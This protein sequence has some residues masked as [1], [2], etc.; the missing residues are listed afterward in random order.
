[1]KKIHIVSLVLF[2]LAVVPLHISFAQLIGTKTIPGSYSSI[3]SALTDLNSQGVG[4]GGV[5]FNIAANYTETLTSM[6]ILTA[7]GTSANP[8]VFQKSG[9]GANPLITSY[10]GTATP[11]S[12]APDGIWA[13]QGSDYVTINGI[14][15]NDPNTSNPGTM[16]FGYGLFKNSVVDGCQNNLITNC[17][18]TL[19]KVNNAA[20]VSPMV[21]GSVGILVINSTPTSSTTALVPTISL[22]SNSYNK[23]YANTIQNAN[24]GIVLSGY[25]DVLPFTLGDTGNDI[26]GSLQSTGNNIL[27]FGGGASDNPSAGIRAIQQW[28]L[29]ISNNTINNNN[30][31]GSN[32]ATTLR[33]IYAQSG[34]S[35][36]VTINNNTLTLNSS[37]TTSQVSVIENGIGSTPA[38]NTIS[39]NN[40][41][42]TNCSN[43]MNTTGLWYGIFNNGAASS[44][45]NISNNSF[46]G[47]STKSVSGNVY[48]IY[49]NAS[50]TSS[51][52][53][54]NNNLSFAF[55]N[56]AAYTGTLYGVYN[57]GATI[58]TNL[59]MNSN[60]FS[61]FNFGSYAN[62]G[63]IQF[64]YNSKPCLNNSYNGNTWT[65]LNL[66]HTGTEYLINNSSNSQVSLTVSNN[67]IV[68][69]YTRNNT[70]GNMYCYYS[71]ASSLGTSSQIISGNNFSNINANINGTGSFYGIYTL[72]GS[73]SPYP[74]KSVYN[75]ILSN[76]NYK[77]SNTFYGIY[78]TN[79]G[80]GSTTSGSSVYNNT[81]ANILD[82]G[83]TYA[84]GMLNTNASPNYPIN[85][86]NNTVCNV[87]SNGKSALVYGFYLGAGSQGQ[88]FY[89]NKVYNIVSNGTTGA[90][91]GV[92]TLNSAPFN[93]F[94]NFVG[95]IKAPIA[96]PTS[97]PYLAAAGI[98]LSSGSNINIQHNT[99]FLNTTS[100]GTNF[101][102][103][104]IYTTSTV[105]SLNLQNNIFVNLSTSK[106]AGYSTAFMRNN[107]NFTNYSAASNNNLFFTG[108]SGTNNPLYYDCSVTYSTLQSF[109]S[110]V[111][112][113]DASSITE[114][115]DFLSVNG[116]DSLYLHINPAKISQ[117]ESGGT[118]ISSPSIIDDY[119]GNARYPNNGYPNNPMYP[120]YAPDM[121]ADEF[122][123]IPL[124]ISALL[125]PQN[126]STGIPAN[127]NLVWSKSQSLLGYHIILATDSN[128]TNIVYNDSTLTDSIYTASNLMPLTYYYWKVRGKSTSAVWTRFS[129]VFNFKTSGTAARVTLNSPLNGMIDLPSTISFKWFKSYDITKNKNIQ[130]NM[131]YWFEYSADSMFTTSVIDTTLTDTTKTISG[132]NTNTKYYWRVKAKNQIGWGEFSLIWSVTTVP[133]IPNIVALVSPLNNITGLP[134]TVTFNW[135]KG[136]ETL[137]NK[138][139]KISGLKVSPLTISRY[140]FEYSTDST[141]TT[142]IIDSTLTDTTKTLTDLNNIT[143][144]FWR[145]KSKN[146]TGW[147]GYSSV[148]SFTTIVPIPGIPILLY[149]ANNS[150]GNALSLNLIW[151]KQRYA[152]G[153][154]FMISTDPD[155]STI[156]INDS[157]LTDS[158]KSVSG[159]TSLTNYY[160]KVRAKSIS[161]WSPFSSAFSF[162]TIGAASQVVL[163]S[164]SNNSTG[165]PVN[166]AFRWYRAFDLTDN[167][168]TV[169]NYWFELSS[170]S[171]FNTIT[172]RDTTLTDTTKS[173]TGLSNQTKYWWRV[174]AK[175][176]I[177]W[178]SFSSVWNLTTIIAAPVAPVLLAPVNNAAGVS[179]MPL[180]TW[181]MVSGAASFRLQVS[182]DSNFATT[183]Y[184]TSGVAALTLT[185]PAGKLTGLT[186]YYWRVNAAN[187]GGTSAW[188]TV[189][190]FMT[191]QNL[192]LNLKVYLEGF[193]DGTSQVQDTVTVYLAGAAMPHAFVDS[194]KVFLS[195]TGTSAV[196]FN[197]APNASYYIVIQHRNHLQT[198]SA[199][200]QAFVTNTAVNYD[201][202]TAAS[203]AFGNNMKQAGSVWVLYGGDANTDGSVDGL[204]IVAFVP[205]FGT[206]G[207]LSCDFNG[208]GD[209]NASDVFIISANY[210]LT[211]AVP[212]VNTNFNP[213]AKQ[214]I[215]INDAIK[216]VNTN[217]NTNT[218]KENVK[219][220]PT[221]NKKT[222]GS[223]NVK[224]QN[225]K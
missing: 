116:Q 128:F 137:I 63:T 23:F 93:I 210:G 190:N 33:G 185:I 208:D 180:I 31:S 40:N 144:Y 166:L 216:N 5:T 98:Y 130:T 114:L 168:M 188:S 51:I 105:S 69:G 124:T 155:F 85:T 119:D 156:I 195:T 4:S 139:N 182:T 6:L 165:L 153:Y 64:I 2:F 122:G 37:V 88:N 61:N 131:L 205:Q 36:N 125:S 220:N 113:R 97:A 62:S 187:A 103:S 20:G 72:D 189:W 197:K 143:R 171:L 127:V 3:S 106:G 59:N 48:L 17:V 217:T 101:S 55:T 83:L 79:L 99:V 164:P 104:S 173:I 186:K 138:S 26:G 60:N 223:D 154:N 170:D 118:I 146:Q 73:A 41:V 211:I 42:I 108:V 84:Y 222:T 39:I 115:P 109:K 215:D 214:K 203:Q 78:L 92:Y 56:S 159:L 53:M 169:S 25:A 70:A 12:A 80:D 112:P 176:Q 191:I 207:Y 52:N 107:N 162:K 132:L 123:G 22:G 213:P 81:V 224:K 184:D 58:T 82:S 151:N 120:A 18:I 57:G 152:T 71:F 7:T 29:N 50:V 121:G 134:L 94:N 43:D 68:N 28:G 149:P 177:G 219:Q 13:L 1:M 218:N 19:N 178:G 91:Y 100:S 111:A 35:A 86:Y 179:L 206:Q 76:I 67:S 14:D 117:I 183:Q 15:L 110:L 141:F 194:A 157:T 175:N 10:V 150:A 95:D 87:A 209:V 199:L 45:L 32:H 74:K 158:V 126:N 27:N 192:S 145:V 204:D 21:D 44:Y 8:I 174:K 148:W 201:F 30:G 129:N 16:E 193:W 225:K 200:T 202:T 181:N 161:G 172:L 47:N 198:W 96:S 212:T 102:S 38:E 147:S 24:Y 46:T 140:W 221:G 54:N 34:T 66:N 89:K 136:A 135:T 142:S 77:S 9:F 133:N 65:G 75:N 11:S 90:S 167:S 160:W 49:N 196:A 163:N